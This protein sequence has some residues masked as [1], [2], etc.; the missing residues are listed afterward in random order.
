MKQKIISHFN[1]ILLSSFEC[2]HVFFNAFVSFF[3]SFRTSRRCSALIR[4]KRSCCH[5]ALNV[6]RSFLSFHVVKDKLVKRS[7]LKSFCENVANDMNAKKQQYFNKRVTFVCK[8]NY[9]FVR[10]LQQAV[11][12]FLPLVFVSQTITI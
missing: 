1:A 11:T 12:S 9:V 6:V 8:K 5:R 2:I 10:T 4:I 3:V 7:R